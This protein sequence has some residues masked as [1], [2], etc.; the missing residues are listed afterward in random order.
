MTDGLL[1]EVAVLDHAGQL[2]HPAQ[3]HLAPAAAGLRGP[4]RGHQRGGLVPQRLAGG[5]HEADLLGQRG[6][7]GD[8]GVLELAQVHLDLAERLPQRGHRHGD[9][10][11][12]VGRRVGDGQPL[13]QQPHLGVGAR[14]ARAR[15]QPAEGEPQHQTQQT[16]G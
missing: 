4:Q 9:V 12:P 8:P 14:G 13:A 15:R 7:G 3:L 11:A 2:D 5:P 10:L 1:G 16:A 6:V